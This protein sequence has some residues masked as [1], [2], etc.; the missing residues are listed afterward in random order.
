M[1]VEMEG[2]GDIWMDVGCWMRMYMRGERRPNGM[3]GR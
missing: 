1:E 2:E 3:E